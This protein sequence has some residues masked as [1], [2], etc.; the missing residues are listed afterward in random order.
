MSGGA[1]PHSGLCPCQPHI[2]LDGQF[3][4]TYIFIVYNGMQMYRSMYLGIS[5]G[6]FALAECMYFMRLPLVQEGSG[7]SARLCDG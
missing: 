6:S 7:T 3:A 4:S 5:M 1:E 2:L